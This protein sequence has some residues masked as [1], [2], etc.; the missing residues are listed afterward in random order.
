MNSR[1]VQ[2]VNRSMTNAA[3]HVLCL[4]QESAGGEETRAQR[5]RF[6]DEARREEPRGED[7]PQQCVVPSFLHAAPPR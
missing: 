6:G 5:G 7:T 3:V 4:I 2:Y 1:A